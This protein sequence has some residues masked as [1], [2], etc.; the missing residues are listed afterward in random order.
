MMIF[1]LKS[2][3]LHRF[4]VSHDIFLTSIGFFGPAKSDRCGYPLTSYSVKI[5]VEGDYS[6]YH[7]RCPSQ[8]ASIITR[9]NFSIDLQQPIR[10]QR[11][12]P[13]KLTVWIDV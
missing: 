5:L 11:L 4:M 13:Y 1:E 7:C 6:K 2:N 9:D 3:V 8:N 12:E 10:I